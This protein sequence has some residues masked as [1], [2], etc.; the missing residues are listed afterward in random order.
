MCR[1]DYTCI[2]AIASGVAFEAVIL[3]GDFVVVMH[4]GVYEW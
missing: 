2:A 4:G 3:H 1:L